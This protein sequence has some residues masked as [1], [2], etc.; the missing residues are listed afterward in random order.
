M[1]RD[2]VPRELRK[3]GAHV[4]VVEAY[5]N[6]LPPEA[7]G[8]ASAIF[9]EPYPDWVTFASSSAV[10]EPRAAH[11]NRTAPSHQHRDDRP[12]YVGHRAPPRPDRDRRSR[13]SHHRG[14]DRGIDQ[15]HETLRR[16]FLRV[17]TGPA[18]TRRSLRALMADSE[19]AGRLRRLRS[20]RGWRSCLLTRIGVIV[21]RIHPRRRVFV[22]GDS[23]TFGRRI[24]LRWSRSRRLD[25]QVAERA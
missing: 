8:Q 14:I 19:K 12:H 4:D 3:R 17:R 16:W 20:L 24:I 2:L 6:V 13:S 1:T 23:A 22:D 7:A 10:S 21:N 5:R 15:R 11:W 25:R 9:R 18:R